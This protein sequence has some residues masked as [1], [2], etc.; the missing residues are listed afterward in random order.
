MLDGA[1]PGRGGRRHAQAGAR[2]RPD[3]DRAGRGGKPDRQSTMAARR[4]RIQT[5]A[6]RRGG[7]IGGTVWFRR[8]AAAAEINGGA[9]TADGA[10]AAVERA[11]QGDRGGARTGGASGRSRRNDPTDPAS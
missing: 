2:T 3:R 4:G 5:A 8:H 7:E 10:A 9:E 1:G 11:T 6:A